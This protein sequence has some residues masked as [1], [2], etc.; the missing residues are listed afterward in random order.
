MLICI[1]LHFISR[2]TVPVEVTVQNI[3]PRH[4]YE[5]GLLI[6]FP[7]SEWWT[8]WRCRAAA[9]R[10]AKWGR[11]PGT[12]WHLLH[13]KTL[14]LLSFMEL[15]L[16]F[17]EDIKR[18][19]EGLTT[20]RGERR[21]KMREITAHKAILLKITGNDFPE[22][23]K[24]FNFIPS[25][26]EETSLMQFF[27]QC[28]YFSPSTLPSDTAGSSS[29][30]SNMLPVPVLCSDAYPKTHNSYLGKEYI[31]WSINPIDNNCWQCTFL[32]NRWYVK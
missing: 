5:L 29:Y 22:H 30:H 3:S 2:H 26:L 19:I 9:L 1:Y 21:K 14:L 10:A 8:E 15:D 23:A 28:F 18:G 13:C 11:I 27:T 4:P 12:H 24:G 25:V 16:L 31:T 7:E 6:C 20:S 32:Q 17:S